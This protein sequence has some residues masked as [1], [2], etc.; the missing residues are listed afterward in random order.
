MMLD[1]IFWRAAVAALC[2]AAAAPASA[3]DWVKLQNR[4][5][6]RAAS[7]PVGLRTPVEMEQTLRM[8]PEML[9]TYRGTTTSYGGLVVRVLYVAPGGGEE[10]NQVFFT[11]LAACEAVSNA[12]RSK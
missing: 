3:Q 7:L 5:C 10:L 1:R 8:F 2:L 11:D 4:V 12:L 6:V 9:G